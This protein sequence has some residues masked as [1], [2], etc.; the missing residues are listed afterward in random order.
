M[1]REIMLLTVP[2]E[3][4]ENICKTLQYTGMDVIQSENIDSVK[5]GLSSHSP[6]FLLLDIDLE[7]A[8]VFLREISRNLVYPP[9]YIVAA[10]TFSSTSDSVSILNS[11]AD[12][13]INKPID[14]NEFLAVINAVLRRE[15]KI[16]RLHVGRLLPCIDH[17]DLSIDPL[18]R[19][20][21]M[22]GERIELTEKEFDVLYFLAY[23]AGSVL[24]KEKIYESVW[25]RACGSTVASVS[26]HVFS[27]RQKLGLDAKDKNYIQTVFGVGYRFNRSD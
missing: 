27:I 9:P 19:I 12:A 24:T 3:H 25:K 14:A 20:V 4:I 18:C 22:R 8:K 2:T 21:E 5:A 16:A 15:Q 6:A 17:K 7:G 10:G 26:G 23:H 11:G 1:K 13:C